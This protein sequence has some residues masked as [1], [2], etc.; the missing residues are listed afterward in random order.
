MGMGSHFI[1]VRLRA[2][3]RPERLASQR[4]REDEKARDESEVAWDV[5]GGMGSGVGVGVNGRIPS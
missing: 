1:F 3:P 2:E 5:G 4:A